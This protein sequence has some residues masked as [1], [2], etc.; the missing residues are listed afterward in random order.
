MSWNICAVSKNEGLYIQEWAAYHKILG[1]EKIFLYDAE[2]DDTKQKLAQYINEG[3]VKFI[4]WHIHPAQWQAYSDYIVGNQF[5]N[6]NDSRRTWA[7]LIDI[8]EFILPMGDESVEDFLKGF[9][10]K[11]SAI[12]IGWQMFGS[13]NRYL[14]PKENHGSVVMNY[15]RCQDYSEFKERMTKCFV[16]PYGCVAHVRDP[17]Y[18]D[19]KPG[20]RVL[21]EDGREL[22]WGDHH[23]RTNDD[24]P[25][26]RMRLNHYFTKSFED[27]LIKVGRDGPD[28]NHRQMIEF[29]IAQ[30]RATDSDFQILGFKEKLI[31]EM[32]RIKAWSL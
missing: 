1:C 29:A 7:A 21:R 25:V 24:F 18:F 20:F 4:P 16:R 5:E 8:D 10:D 30:E 6:P 11:V 28:G 14:R 22:R 9:D 19:P 13:N 26:E 2:T 31:E 12:G 23:H 32:Q 17:H 15:F 27:W 3:F